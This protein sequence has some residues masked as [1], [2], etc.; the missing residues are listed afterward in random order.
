MQITQTILLSWPLE[1]SPYPLRATVI[2]L[3]LTMETL[4]VVRDLALTPYGG[5]DRG[6]MWV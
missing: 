3:A 4:A 1:Q 5:E 2:W 6:K